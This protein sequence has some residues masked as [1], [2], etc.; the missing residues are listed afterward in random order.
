MLDSTAR[1]FLVYLSGGSDPAF[2]VA[3]YIKI[4]LVG[5]APVSASSGDVSVK[6]GLPYATALT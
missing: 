5:E 1:S 2:K 4:V 3:G 6:E